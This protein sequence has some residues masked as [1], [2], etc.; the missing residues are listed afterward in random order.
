MT[1]TQARIHAVLLD[2]T[3]TVA[4]AAAAAGT[5]PR[6]TRTY[7]GLM[8]DQGLVTRSRVPSG[9]RT[10]RYRAIR[11][12]GGTPTPDPDVRPRFQ[13][14]PPP[15]G[16]SMTARERLAAAIEHHPELGTA[17]LEHLDPPRVA[18]T[19]RRVRRTPTSARHPN[20]F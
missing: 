20:R 4:E 5:N 18:P 9:P 6:S 15:S 3:L 19:K 17:L 8:H 13:R 7:L 10:Y 11:Q 1:P 16:P 2:R 12:P 14:P